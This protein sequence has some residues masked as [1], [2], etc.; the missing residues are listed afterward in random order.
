[1]SALQI[2]TTKNPHTQVAEKS[3]SNLHKFGDI[4]AYVI[5]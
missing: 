4:K 3:S 1:M 2:Q 5:I